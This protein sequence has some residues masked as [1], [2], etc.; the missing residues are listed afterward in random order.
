MCA[1]DFFSLLTVSLQVS[2]WVDPSFIDLTGES[3]SLSG[4]IKGSQVLCSKAEPKRPRKR[5]GETSSSDLH[6]SYLL[7]EST[8]RDQDEP[9][10]HRYSPCSKVIIIASVSTFVLVSMNT[11]NQKLV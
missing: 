3:F 1:L 2:R 7:K 10:V 4:R 9:W 5:Q 8:Q 6:A 11:F